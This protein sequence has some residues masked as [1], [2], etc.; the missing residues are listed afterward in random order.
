[1]NRTCSLRVLLIVES[2][3]QG[4]APLKEHTTLVVCYEPE[5]PKVV[6]Y[7]YNYKL[8]KDFLFPKK[9]FL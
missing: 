8:Q 3:N 4:K 5:K 9:D 1:M 2:L 6:N 7:N